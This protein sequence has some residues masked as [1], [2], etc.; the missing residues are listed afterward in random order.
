MQARGGWGLILTSSATD[1]LS[2]M[3]YQTGSQLSR[4]RPRQAVNYVQ[5]LGGSSG[6]L[7][8]FLLPAFHKR[9][10]ARTIVHHT[11]LQCAGTIL[12]LHW[13]LQV[14][15]AD[16]ATDEPHRGR[17]TPSAGI[18]TATTAVPQFCTATCNVTP[19]C[20]T[21]QTYASEP[22]RR[23]SAV[24]LSP[25]VEWTCQLHRCGSNVSF[26]GNP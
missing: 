7:H 12:A 3:A 14:R 6:L 23:H 20:A 21:H 16:S 13:W 19:L 5:C 25:Q 11:R 10:A 8:I 4:R 9:R 24:Q 15:P 22:T 1:L 2:R 26:D 17:G 18:L